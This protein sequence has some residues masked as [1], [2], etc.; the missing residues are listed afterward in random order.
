MNVSSLFVE[1]LRTS[2]IYSV[3]DIRTTQFSLNSLGS[4]IYNVL[5]SST[6]QGYAKL[7]S[8]NIF[9]YP[10]QSNQPPVLT[11][12]L[13]TKEYVDQSIQNSNI[14]NH[15]WSGSNTFLNPI[16]L[17]N[18]IISNTSTLNI[19]SQTQIGYTYESAWSTLIDLS[20]NLQ[21]ISSITFNIPGVWQIHTQY[22]FSGEGIFTQIEAGYTNGTMYKED[23]IMTLETNDV[24]QRF[25]PYIFVNQSGS[26]TIDIVSSIKINTGSFQVR[27]KYF[28]VRIA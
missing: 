12:H 2:S 7:N 27:C 24:I 15:T 14:T 17:L 1:N 4:Y 26:T 22:E 13:T 28:Y 21:T 5:N 10:P 25:V 6:I 20:N 23:V 11:N 19:S 18:G 16:S 9:T 8:T 3:N